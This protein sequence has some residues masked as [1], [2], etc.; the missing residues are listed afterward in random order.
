MRPGQWDSAG[1]E[2]R[3]FET[4]VDSER[5]TDGLTAAHHA[6]LFAWLVRAAMERAGEERGEAAIRQ[7]VRTYGEERGHRMALRA[8]ANGERLDMES[9]MA[10]GEWAAAPGE[11]EQVVVE[12]GAD[13]R[14]TVLRCPW[15]R[16]WAKDDVMA[17]GRLYCLEIDEALARGFNPAL[18][19]DVNT[20]LSNDGEPCELVFHE[21]GARGPRRGMV[22]PWAYH[23]GHLYK[24]VGAVLEKE[25]GGAGREAA[26]EALAVFT[27]RFG[28]DAAQAVLSYADVDF[29]RLP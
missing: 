5:A 20:T 24:T 7:A 21:V 28:E 23:L 22:M 18:R 10:Y 17:Y 4:M 13:V 25:L 19:L 14:S 8:E 27:E 6:L 2:G 9:Y 1:D 26:A 11:S 12:D 3:V 16:A 29:G 15:H